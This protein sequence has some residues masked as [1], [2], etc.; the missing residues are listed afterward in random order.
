VLIVAGTHTEM[1]AASS[2]TRAKRASLLEVNLHGR[3][4]LPGRGAAAAARRAG[5]ASASWSL[6]GGL[7]GLPKALIYGPSKAALINFAEGLYGRP[8]PAGHRRLPGQPGLR[9]HAADAEERLRHAGADDRAGCRARHARRIAAG[10]LRDSLSRRFTRWLKLLRILPYR[11]A[12]L[13]GA[14][15]HGSS[16]RDGRCCAH[17]HGCAVLRVDQSGQRARLDE[18]YAPD[19][20]FKDPFNE[21]RGV[22]AIRTHLRPTCSGRSTRP[23][24][25][26]HDVV[27]QDAQAFITWDFRFRMKRFNPGTGHPGRQ[28]PAF[29]AD[30]GGLS[31][32][33]L[34]RSRGA[35]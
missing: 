6:G 4:E 1:R 13:G 33:L 29:D 22:P 28:P 35:V 34:G 23:R 2:G 30:G 17:R 25:V 32:G 7:R 12:V 16:N 8:A 14:A 21:V 27:A 20:Y 18:F 26:V 3:A 31:S 19:A 15:G 10:P 11:A 24:F 5:A 9:R